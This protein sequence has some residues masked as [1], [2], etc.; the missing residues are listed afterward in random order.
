[1]LRPARTSPL[2]D[3][4]WCCS[5]FTREMAPLAEPLLGLLR[6]HEQ[7]VDPNLLKLA[8]AYQL[9]AQRLGLAAGTAGRHGMV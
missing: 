6:L 5:F 3:S 1:M 2:P 8:Q 7:A 9:A 4:A